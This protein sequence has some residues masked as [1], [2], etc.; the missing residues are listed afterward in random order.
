MEFVSES[1]FC[2]P[3]QW[4]ASASRVF[5]KDWR[6]REAKQV[7]ALETPS[8]FGMHIS[9]LASVTF[10]KNHYDMSIV[11][12]MLLVG[13]DEAAQLLDRGDDD[14]RIRIL[15][16]F[17]KHRCG[18]IR[19]GGSLLEPFILPHGLIIQVLAINDKQHL[20]DVRQSTRQLCRFETGQGFSASGSV[21][22]VSTCR[23]FAQL[24]LVGRRGNPLQDL[25]S[26]HDLIWTHHKQ[27]AVHIE[28]AILGQ[29]IQ[30]GVLRKKGLCEPVQIG[31]GSVFAVSPPTCECETVGC[32]AF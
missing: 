20:V 4:I 31:D 22:D 23:Y 16:L 1:L 18:G 7:V 11:D 19:I 5:G 13:S 3:T 8:D 14:S 2:G 25:F 9:E 10:V 6:T 27:L 17:L 28:H 12:V 15:Q 26:R 32:L 21:P 29:N 30:Q 24:P